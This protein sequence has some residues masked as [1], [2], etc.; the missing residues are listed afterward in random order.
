MWGFAFAVEGWT[1]FKG[2]DI[3][4]R[5]G[6]PFQVFPNTFGGKNVGFI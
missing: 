6:S 3:I 4:N 2:Y 5:M 1:K